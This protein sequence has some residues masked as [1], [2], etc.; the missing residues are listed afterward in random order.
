MAYSCQSCQKQY[1][2]I[3]D[4]PNLLIQSDSESKKS[5][6]VSGMFDKIAKIYENKLV[7][8]ITYHVLAGLKIPS[9]KE[10]IGK[11]MDRIDRQ[12]GTILYIACGTGICTRSVAKIAT[13]IFGIDISQRILEQA[14]KLTEKEGL[15]NIYL[16]KA[17]AEKLPFSDNYFDEICSSGAL[18]YFTNTYKAL[19]EMR[20]VLKPNSPLVVMTL[21]RRRFLKYKIVY[22]HLKED[23]GAHVFKFNALMRLLEEV[24]FKNISSEV[25]GSMLLFSAMKKI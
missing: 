2:I 5:T 23:H 9:V 18:H 20:R 3:N 11:V 8:L 14:K 17:D 16:S 10:L 25:Y 1:F 4:I 15:T 6:N 13:K 12:G 22:E 24:G 21:I 19:K 7:Y